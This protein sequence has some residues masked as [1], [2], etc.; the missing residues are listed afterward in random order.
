MFCFLDD[1]VRT[2]IP[3]YVINLDL[4]PAQR[5]SQLGKEKAKEVCRAEMLIV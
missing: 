2:K 4:P 1:Y 3:T 5:W